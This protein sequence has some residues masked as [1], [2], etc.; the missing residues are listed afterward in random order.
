MCDKKYT[1]PELRR[2]AIDLETAYSDD[3]RD[4]RD[5]KAALVAAKL[6]A[7]ADLDDALTGETTGTAAECHIVQRVPLLGEIRIQG[8]RRVAVERPYHDE[9]AAH[10][11]HV[12]F[13]WAADPV[14]EDRDG[15]LI[16]IF[17]G[18]EDAGP[19]A[20]Y[21][22]GSRQWYALTG[23]G[24]HGKRYACG[25]NWSAVRVDTPPEIFNRLEKVM[26][27]ASRIAQ[28]KA[29]L[30]A[31]KLNLFAAQQDDMAAA[32]ARQSTR[33]AYDGQAEV[34]ASK[35]G[36]AASHADITRA[37]ASLVLAEAGL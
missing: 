16:R 27:Q 26:E 35:A 18:T 32:Y 7:Q 2:I 21:E 34:C 11:I 5:E 29:R 25:G 22:A 24:N 4:R 14:A 6:R 10:G 17:I 9:G 8:G 36:I 20:H 13:E 30:E 1:A 23:R 37:K 33:P 28:A 12:A 31:A 19:L 3:H 15:T